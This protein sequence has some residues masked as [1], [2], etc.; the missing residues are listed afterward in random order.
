VGEIMQSLTKLISSWRKWLNRN[1]TF[2]KKE[3]DELEDH[4]MEEIDYLVKRENLTEEEAFH[5]AMMD[6]GKRAVLDK[7]FLKVKSSPF[8]ILHWIRMNSWSIGV[9]LLILAFSAGYIAG[10]Y[11]TINLRNQIGY[12]K[13][14]KGSFV[15]FDVSNNKK[16][17]SIKKPKIIEHRDYKN[18]YTFSVDEES[19]TYNVDQDND[20]IDCLFP[21]GKTKWIKENI[22]SDDVTATK[23]GVLVKAWVKDTI[24]L[25]FFD[26]EGHFKWQTIGVHPTIGPDG[27][28]YAFKP[29]EKVFFSCDANGKTRWENKLPKKMGN[30]V[31]TPTKTINPLQWVDQASE[32]TANNLMNDSNN[33]IGAPFFD[34]QRNIYLLT[35]DS[36]GFLYL[37][38]FAYTGEILFERELPITWREIVY[39]TS[40]FW[41]NVYGKTF[42]DQFILFSNSKET[43]ADGNLITAFSLDG[44]MKWSYSETGGRFSDK[45][46]V[47][48]PN[49]SIIYVYHKEANKK[50]YLHSLS[51][52]GKF[53]WEKQII[54]S[55]ITDKGIEPTNLIS[56]NSKNIFLGMTLKPDGINRIFCFDFKGNQQWKMDF[57]NI[58]KEVNWSNSFLSFYPDG[59]L[60][61]VDGN[62]GIVYSIQDKSTNK[63]LK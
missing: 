17:S 47:D 23:N 13:I 19:S 33:I 20:S 9:S 18:I 29:N 39:W 3:L 28:I 31:N 62:N 26:K 37:Y 56:D 57:P 48:G 38:K 42:T 6:V 2:Q 51:E 54:D 44:K 1:Q 35:T 15:A 30:F 27:M 36:Y 41:A 60:R 25:L 24:K 46:F 7:D 43:E 50:Y 45:H 16:A 32:K 4:L 40:D 53:L 55:K 22:V 5:K 63:G 52:D 10:W 21:D 59:I 49:D 12:T 14:R 58:K 34:K 8:K 11:P 61:Y